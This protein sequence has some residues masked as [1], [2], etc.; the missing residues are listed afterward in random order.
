MKQTHEI[1][2][3]FNYQKTFDFLIDLLPN[4]GIFVEC[5]AWMGKSSSY[6]CDKIYELKPNAKIYIVDTWLGTDTDITG[7]LASNS[8][9]YS[10]FLDNMGDRKFTTIKQTSKLAA[11][12]F[13]DKSLDIIF[14]DMGH[15]YDEVK[16]DLLYWRPKLKDSGIIA[17]HDWFFPG[18]SSAVKECFK[19]IKLSDGDCWIVLSS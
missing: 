7:Q 3:W 6:L 12:Q 19:D 10:L 2:G 17:G 16:Q 15:S 1:D 4:D 18:V 9:V 13:K 11:Q 8:D 5:G 14:I